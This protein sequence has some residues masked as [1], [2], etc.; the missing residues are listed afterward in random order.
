MSNLTAVAY[1]GGIPPRNNNPEKPLILNNFLAGVKASGDNA[2]AHTGMDPIQCDVALIQGFVHEHGKTA[3]HLVLRQRAVDMQKNNGKKSLI[4]DSN[5]FLYA[6]PGNTRHYLRY[7][8]DG[9]FPTTGF[10]FDKDI[11]PTRWQKISSN[12]RIKLKPYRTSGNHILVCCQRNGGWSMQ[13]IAVNNWLEQTLQQLRNRTDRP[14][15]VRIHPGDKKWMQWFNQKLITKHPNVTLSQRHIL[16]DLQNCWAS[17]VYNSSP[18][19]ASIIEGVPTFVTD[20]N[21]EISQSNGV[22]NTTLK[23]IEDPKMFDRQGWV[24]KLSMC[25]WNFDELK[26]GEAWQFFRQYVN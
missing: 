13:G 23:R 1:F 7:S 6:D 12:L 11:D 9:V 14:I 20:P 26:S 3:P 2:I 10:Y 8:F 15:V 18:S 21:P 22:C 16:E 17:V 5:L 25:H 24:E 4:V 19:I